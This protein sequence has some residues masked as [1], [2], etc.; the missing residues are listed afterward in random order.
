[1]GFNPHSDGQKLLI[2]ITYKSGF[3]PGEDSE[4]TFV[5]EFTRFISIFNPLGA[6]DGLGHDDIRNP[7]DFGNEEE[8]RNALAIGD[9]RRVEEED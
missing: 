8:L 4:G 5:Q 9:Y 6:I 7:E 3:N 1:M 2:Q